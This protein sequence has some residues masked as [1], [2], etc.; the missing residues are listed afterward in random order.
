MKRIFIILFATMLTACSKPGP[1][2][3]F[4][5]DCDTR[6][7]EIVMLWVENCISGGYSDFSCELRSRELFCE[8]RPYEWNRL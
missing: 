1:A 3:P 2:T 7:N 4:V 6:D 5:Y 8:K